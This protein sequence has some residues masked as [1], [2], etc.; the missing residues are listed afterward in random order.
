MERK[1]KGLTAKEKTLIKCIVSCGT[2]A[3]A[4]YNAG[5]DRNPQGSVEER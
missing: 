2:A 1:S 4:A 3:E 5:I